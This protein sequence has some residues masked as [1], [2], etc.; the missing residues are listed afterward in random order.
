MSK[1]ILAD[2]LIVLAV[3]KFMILTISGSVILEIV[4]MVI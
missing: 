2:G 1:W 3:G 4:E